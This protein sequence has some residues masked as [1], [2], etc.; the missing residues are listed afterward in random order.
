MRVP[1]AR[2][3]DAVGDF[4]S[5]LAFAYANTRKRHAPDFTALVVAIEPMTIRLAIRFVLLA[6]L[7][8]AASLS[9]GCDSS[10]TTVQEILRRTIPPGDAVP[11][12]SESARSGQSF[13][14]IW[15]F[16]THLTPSEYQA[17]LKEHI[18]DFEVVQEGQSRLS[19]ATHIGGDAYR[20][21]MTAEPGTRT[22]HIHAQL[23]ASA[24]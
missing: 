6:G 9:A 19:L 5:A 2:V 10:R 4:F 21:L 3:A 18:R 7:V 16:D 1:S 8:S 20:L 11:T 14:F 23:T 13:Q 17:W 12:Q 15:D 22:T 24:D